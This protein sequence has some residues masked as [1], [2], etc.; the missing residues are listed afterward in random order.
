MYIGK[1]TKSTFHDNESQA[2]AI[3]ERV[4]WDVCGPFSTTS[5]TKHWYYVISID[6]FSR[7]YWIFFHAEERSYVLQVLWEQ[8]TCE[9]YTGKKVK[10]LR[11]ENG[12]ENISNEFKNFCA[13]EGIRRELIAAHNPQPNAVVERKKKTIVGE[14]WVMFHDQVL[15]LHLWEEACNT[16]VFLQNII[17][18]WILG[19]STL[20]ET[21]SGKIL[22]VSY[23]KIL[24]SYVYF[25]VTKYAR[26]KLEPTT[27]LGIFLGYFLHFYLVTSTLGTIFAFFPS[28]L[29]WI[30]LFYLISLYFCFID[31]YDVSFLFLW[32]TEINVG[33]SSL[34]FCCPSRCYS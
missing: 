4:H 26:K 18:H 14:A 21:F 34:V 9:K 22:D 13:S 24:V 28:F 1:Y 8:G 11:S 7:K 31:Y 29:S 19:M 12:G 5:T 2:K 25:H 23:I 16:T 27:K 15:P 30:V 32:I 17:P 33:R 6:D 20:E 3:L 10:A